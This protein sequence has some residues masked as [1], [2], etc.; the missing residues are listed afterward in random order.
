MSKFLVWLRDHD[1]T[2]LYRICFRLK[3]GFCESDLWDLDH[4]FAK[5]MLPR[6]KMF[7]LDLDHC[8]IEDFEQWCAMVDKMVYAMEMIVSEVS[9]CGQGD[10]EE[11]EARV[12]EG[13]ELFG[14]YFRGLWT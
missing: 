11:I 14:K 10:Y 13:L 5:Y 9:W 8:P 7:R 1:W 6:L 3:Y 2:R 12:Q 4:T